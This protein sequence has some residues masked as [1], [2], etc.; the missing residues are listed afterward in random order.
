MT[1]R[2]QVRQVRQRG[3]AVVAALCFAAASTAAFLAPAPWTGRADAALLPIAVP[4]T[5]SMK[6]DTIATIPPPG[7]LGNDVDLLGGATA[8]LTAQPTH[9]N[10]D[11]RPDGGY[12]YQPDAG[13]VGTD[14]FRYRP[15]GLLGLGTTVTITITNAAPVAANDSYN[16]VTGVQLTVPAPGVLGNDT[17]A[18]GDAL[19]ATLVDGGGNGSLDLNADGSFTFKS[20]GSFTG[21]RTFT[22]QVSD[23]LTTSGTATVSIDV[24]APAPTPAPT[25]TPTPTPVPTP[26]P[27]PKPTPTPTP[28]P[29]LPLPTLPLP[30]LPLPTLPLPTLPLP[31]LPLP[32]PQPTSTATPST[33]PSTGPTASPSPGAT[34]G[35]PTSSPSPGATDALPGP[36]ASPDPQQSPGTPGI[37]PPTGGDPGSGGGPGGNDERFSVGGAGLG[38]GIGLGDINLGSFDALFEWAVPALVL[39]VPGLLLAI[40]VLAQAAGGLL[41][42][43]V[44]RRW[45]GGFGLRRRRAATADAAS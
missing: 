11:L 2:R 1:R 44:V 38:P 26:T 34:G 17:D 29:T 41:W 14:V 23:G 33:G 25:P 24:T 7:V 45:L 19:T 39:T 32:T 15:S 31:T 27:T 42:L 5:H 6:H 8:I 22:Y 9:G 36:D 30:T 13:Y 3:A 18:D 4:D 10:V 35:T 21:I 43:P 28:T 20:G 12:T 37:I 40:A 16:A